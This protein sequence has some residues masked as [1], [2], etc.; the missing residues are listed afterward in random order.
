MFEH[1]IALIMMP[2]HYASAA[3]LGFGGDNPGIAFLIA[4]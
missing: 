4:E 3:K 1:F 2:E